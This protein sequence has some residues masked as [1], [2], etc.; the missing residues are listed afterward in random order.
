VDCGLWIVKHGGLF[1]AATRVAPHS[2]NPDLIL[3][4]LRKLNIRNTKGNATA[5][6]S[7]MKM[8]DFTFATI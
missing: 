4:R 3:N 2:N 1:L 8:G 5:I 7:P 6:A